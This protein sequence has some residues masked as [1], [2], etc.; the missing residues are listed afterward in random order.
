MSD[1]T[2]GDREV[3]H[4]CNQCKWFDERMWIPDMC[5]CPQNGISPVTGK[6]DNEYC[7]SL[8]QNPNK[9]GPDGNWFKPDDRTW[10][11]KW[12]HRAFHYGSAP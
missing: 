6:T 4:A 10:F 12:R 11:S 1:P 9:C 2:G 8:R 3:S 5:W 7:L